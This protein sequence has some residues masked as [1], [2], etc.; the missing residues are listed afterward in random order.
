MGKIKEWLLLH[1]LPV[2]AKETVYKEN[3]KLRA[4]LLEKEQEIERLSAYSDGL[5]YALRR[6]IV[7]RNE[8]KQ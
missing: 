5:E 6:R 7:I 1:F 8:V 4:A 2:W 3:K